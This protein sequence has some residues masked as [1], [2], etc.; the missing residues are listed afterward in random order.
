MHYAICGGGGG[1]LTAAPIE[2]TDEAHYAA[3]LGG[4]VFLRISRDAIDIEFVR[5]NAVTEYAFRLTK[6]D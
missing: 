3:T 6:E 5:M 2:W 1:R 4:F